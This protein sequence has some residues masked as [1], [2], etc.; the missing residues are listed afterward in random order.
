MKK[1]LSKKDKEKVEK[2]ISLDEMNFL[3]KHYGEVPDTY[4]ERVDMWYDFLKHYYL[5][6]E[7]DHFILAV[8]LL[9]MQ[10]RHYFYARNYEKK[11]KTDPV[12]DKGAKGLL[13]S[14]E[15]FNINF[16]NIESIN[17]KVKNLKLRNKDY[18]A[19]T[20]E[21]LTIKDAVIKEYIIEGKEVINELFKLM[22]NNSSVFQKISDREKK[23]LE[24]ATQILRKNK[25]DIYKRKQFSKILYKYLKVHLPHYSHNKLC[26][27]GGFLLFEMGI[28]P[29][30]SSDLSINKQ[31]KDYLRKNF[32][33]AL[34]SD[35]NS[36]SK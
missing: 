8:I 5:N 9:E 15:L 26:V 23:Y 22:N 3:E 17:I 28:M 10:S 12:V 14:L 21:A 29:E 35:I 1:S 19:K 6:E 2:Y 25:P 4:W 24:T 18:K 7:I 36:D 31:F 33:K 13:E 11:F 16:L 30:T 32:D 20:L 34:R 27:M